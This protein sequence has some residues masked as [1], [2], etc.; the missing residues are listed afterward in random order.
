[1]YELS[2]LARTYPAL[3][4]VAA[5]GA[6]LAYAKAKDAVYG[7]PRDNGDFDKYR[8]TRI[9]EMYRYASYTIAFGMLVW[10]FH[11]SQLIS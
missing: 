5:L 11:G 2:E 1:M 6:I 8:A 10:L 3:A 9:K 7:Q 4:V